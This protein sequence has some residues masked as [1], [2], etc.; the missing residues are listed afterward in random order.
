MTMFDTV[1]YYCILMYTGSFW[2][3]ARR[4]AR[5]VSGP[6]LSLRTKRVSRRGCLY[7]SSWSVRYS[8]IRFYTFCKLTLLKQCNM[9][10][11]RERSARRKNQQFGINENYW[12]T[13][14]SLKR[15]LCL[16]RTCSNIMSIL[17]ESMHTPLA[18]R[19]YCIFKRFTDLLFLNEYT[20]MYA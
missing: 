11:C 18:F 16:K 13:C 7:V 10:Q 20:H 1:L 12:Y 14:I 3:F 9:S 8:Y 4:G 15:T 19:L 5:G 2:W 6:K 17:L